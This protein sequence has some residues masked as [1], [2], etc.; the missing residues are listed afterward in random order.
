MREYLSSFLASLREDPTT[1]FEYSEPVPV[2]FEELEEE[3]CVGNIYVRLFLRNPDFQLKDPEAFLAALIAE[4][5]REDLSEELQNNLV[6]AQTELY[7]RYSS[8][9]AFQ[10]YSGFPRLLQMGTQD[11][12]CVVLVFVFAYMCV[13]EYLSMG[14]HIHSQY[15]SVLDL[16]LRS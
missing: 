11:G 3:Q 1:L 9:P 10:R 2:H 14:V 7:R 16:L 13:S 4:M 12:A 8:K 6:K 5:D 15:V